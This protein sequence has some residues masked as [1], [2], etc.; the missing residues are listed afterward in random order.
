[1]VFMRSSQEGPPDSAPPSPRDLAL[2]ALPAILDND[3][4]VMPSDD[5]APVRRVP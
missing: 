1:M 4:L 5:A 3:T 2:P